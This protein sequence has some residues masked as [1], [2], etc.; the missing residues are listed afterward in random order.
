MTVEA[1]YTMMLVTVVLCT[2]GKKAPAKGSKEACP[3]EYYG[4][5]IGF[6]VISGGHAGGWICGAALNPAVAI[7][8]DIASLH[9]G[10]WWWV[11]GITELIGAFAAAH[12]H[13]L[14]R[15]DDFGGRIT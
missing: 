15:A 4:L 13:R 1:L 10:A 12:L 2:A 11:Y 8:A 7:G 5:A 9:S 14:L 3:N 6:T